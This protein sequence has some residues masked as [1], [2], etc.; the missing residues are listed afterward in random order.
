MTK[1]LVPQLRCVGVLPRT[2]YR[3]YSFSVE[4]KEKATRVV[5]LTIDESVFLQKQLLYQEAPD[6]CYQKL[7]ADLSNEA[8]DGPMRSR[9]SITD[10]DVARYRDSHPNVKLRGRPG[11]RRSD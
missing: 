7:L 9:R 8:V 10:S 6:L 2:G 11:A 1:A 5:V 3:E 4:D